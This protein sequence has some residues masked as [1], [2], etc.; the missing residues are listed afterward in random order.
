[1][2]ILSRSAMPRELGLARDPRLLGVALRQIQVTQAARIRVAD[3]DDAL[4]TDGFH[5]FESVNGFRWTDG[6]AAIPAE[7]FAG[8]GGPLEVVLE[9]GATTRYL[10][11][12]V[13]L[14]SA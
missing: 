9:L 12:G 3:A 4:L 14:Q 5:D 13:A 10:D 8:L 2:R 11:D 1:M 7:L 6:D